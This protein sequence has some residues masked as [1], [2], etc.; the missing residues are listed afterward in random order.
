MEEL[1]EIKSKLKQ[2]AHCW[3]E[4]NSLSKN[5]VYDIND[6]HV[7]WNKKINYEDNKQVI[8]QR[9]NKLITKPTA[10][11]IKTYKPPKTFSITGLILS[12]ISGFFFF[13][14]F[15]LGV[16][17]AAGPQALVITTVLNA[18]GYLLLTIGI[19]LCKAQKNSK[20]VNKIP[21]KKFL[22]ILGIVLMVVG[23]LVV[24]CQFA[25]LSIGIDNNNNSL[26]NILFLLFG[27]FL[28]A[29]VLCL[30]VC[31][32]F[33][34]M[35]N[36]SLMEKEY[37]N[38][39]KQVEEDKKYNEE[40]LPKDLEEYE[41]KFKI[42]CD[43][44]IKIINETHKKIGEYFAKIEVI[45]IV[46]VSQA[47][48]SQNL[49]DYIYKGAADI[50]EAFEMLERDKDK[51]DKQLEEERHSQQEEYEDDFVIREP[52]KYFQ[53]LSSDLQEIEIKKAV[54]ETFDM[55]I[56]NEGLY[57]CLTEHERLYMKKA[58][59]ENIYDINNMY[60]NL[61]E[62][63]ADRILDTA[64]F[65]INNK[66]K[67]KKLPEYKKSTRHKIGIIATC[68]CVLG[69]VALIPNLVIQ[70]TLGSEHAAVIPLSAVTVILVMVGLFMFSGKRLYCKVCGHKGK[71]IKIDESET[72]QEISRE[73]INPLIQD[74]AVATTKDAH[75]SYD[76]NGNAYREKIVNKK[77]ITKFYRCPHCGREWTD[78]EIRSVN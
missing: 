4:I 66:F 48:Y 5:S 59:K 22:E 11:V 58:L 64:Y 8:N 24:V 35:C 40:Q 49:L 42:L 1:K 60:M 46:S 10:K 17:V 71:V 2:V 73:R 41:R 34:K 51:I 7:N 27:N 29:G 54:E 77:H 3:S 43:E 55:H 28:S 21:P 74:F 32:M 67:N 13:A 62:F 75:I 65:I 63:I 15:A 31:L 23:C 16:G 78:F 18:I 38:K 37:E 72:Y 14:M 53:G 25:T 19:C 36:S 47:K 26:S 39:L 56:K 50:K 44:Q 6:T 9:V 68:L 12:I 70:F 57:E 33:Y 69:A 20:T 45:D 61:R 52:C 30:G 76:A